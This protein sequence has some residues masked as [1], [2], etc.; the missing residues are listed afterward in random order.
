MDF[1]IRPVRR[2]FGGRIRKSALRNAVGVAVVLPPRK[3]PVIQGRQYNCHPNEAELVSSFA[4]FQNQHRRP[5]LCSIP[6]C[7]RSPDGA[8]SGLTRR[9]RLRNILY[10]PICSC[11]WENRAIMPDALYGAAEGRGTLQ[12][13]IPGENTYY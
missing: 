13:P 1:P 6:C 2:P 5:V 8:A 11:Q 10:T 12:R 9:C 7:G 3:T 4:I